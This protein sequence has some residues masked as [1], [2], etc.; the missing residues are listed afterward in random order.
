MSLKPA[1]NDA[2]YN[3]DIHENE[4]YVNKKIWTYQQLIHWINTRNRYK[5]YTEVQERIAFNFETAGEPVN[6]Q[7]LGDY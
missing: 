7:L 3:K 4:I 6:P 5:N 2:L 1:V